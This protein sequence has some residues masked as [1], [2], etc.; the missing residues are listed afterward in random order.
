MK[1]NEIGRSM[2]EMLTVLAL[3][4]ILTVGSIKAYQSGQS[5]NE[6]NKIHE[7]VSIASLNG[8]TKM[9]QLKNDRIWKAIGKKKDDYKCVQSLSA[10]RNGKVTII[11][12]GGKCDEIKDMLISRWPSHVEKKGANTYIYT[13]PEDND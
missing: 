1:R 6:A 10:E 11:F 9:T 12:N 13:P 5:Q 2:L 4:G 7:L 3:I 8:L